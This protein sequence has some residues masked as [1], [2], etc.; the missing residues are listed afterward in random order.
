MVKSREATATIQIATAGVRRLGQTQRTACE[1][2]SPPSRANANAILDAEVTVANPQRYWARMI[3]AISAAQSGPGSTAFTIQRNA[4]SPCPAASG[5]P[6]A[7]S[8]TV[9]SKTQPTV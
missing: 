7:A 5:R 4:P 1:Q 2:G 9:H 6:G 8:T 3:A